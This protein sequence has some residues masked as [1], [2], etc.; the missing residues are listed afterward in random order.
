MNQKKVRFAMVGMGALAFRHLGGVNQNSD[1]AETVSI[2]DIDPDALKKRGDEFGIPEER[3]YTSYDKMLA[4][5][6]FD[7][8]IIITPDQIHREQ[9]VAA[10]NAGYHVLCEK[11]LAQTLE[12]CQEM[13]DAVDKSGKL[14]M[15]GQVCRKAPG[16]VKA[17]ELIDS[18]EIGELFFVESEYAHDYQYLGKAWRWDPVNLRYSVIGGGCH[19]IDLLRWIAGDPEKVMAL[20]N[21]KVLK[22]WPVDDTT[23]AIMQFPNN[24]VG[25]IFCSIGAKRGYTM[26]TCLYGTKGTII[27][28]NRS[29]Y[30]TLYHH[31]TDDNGK[32]S[33]PSQEVPVPVKDHNVA[34]EIR[35]MALAIL[36]DAPIVCTVREGS[37]TVAVGLAAVESAANGGIPVE[38]KY[39]K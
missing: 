11:P 5:G 15:T 36:E 8:V 19:A 32:N 6:G 26:R 18:G 33:Y 17:K 29:P 7:C 12:D 24:V 31:V 27:C 39:I 3:R 21:R 28:D 14:F 9:A 23:I 13:V 1:V 35:E 16:F 10:L 25:K 20:A 4:D 30:I 37:N 38:P 22:D 34:A 2:C